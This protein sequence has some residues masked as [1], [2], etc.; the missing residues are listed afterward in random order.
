MA[1]LIICSINGAIHKCCAV[2]V[3]AY[4]GSG[5]GPITVYSN[6]S[7]WV[8]LLQ[9][10][11]TDAEKAEIARKERERLRS[12]AKHKKD[13]L[14]KVRDLQ[15]QDTAIGEASCFSLNGCFAT[16]FFFP[17]FYNDVMFL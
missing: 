6:L 7:A 2:H 12:Q 3:S 15:N 9:L 10:G 11:E 14:E 5:A 16:L 1:S 17:H 4:A 13:Q 8:D